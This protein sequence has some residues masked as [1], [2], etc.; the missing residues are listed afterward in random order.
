LFPENFIV[1]NPQFSTITYRNNS[2][3]S[4]YHSMQAQVTLRPTNGFS[5][6]GTY[7]WAKNLGIPVGTGAFTDPS[8][9]S[10]DYTYTAS[11]RAH[12]FRSNGTLELPFGPNKL[13]LGNSSGWLARVVERWQASVILNLNSG[14]R[15]DI[16]ATQGAG[17]AVTQT[18]LYGNAVPDVVGPFNPD[19]R[20]RWN[21]NNNATGTAHGGTYFN[22]PSPL[23]RVTDPQCAIT[24][25]TDRMGFN[26][27]ANGSCTLDALADAQTGQIILQNPRPGTRGNLGQNTIELPGSWSFD[28]NVSKTFRVGESK[29]LQL[30]IDA[31]N[32]LNHPVPND[33]DLGLNSTGA[34]LF[35]D[36]DEKGNQVRQFQGQVRFN[37]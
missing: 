23:V 15:Q 33:P 25:Y 14:G 4:N 5:Y 8:D 13:V 24:N 26:M 12:D 10:A 36:I 3:S 2:D 6:Q 34:T 17:F 9:R 16:A 32:V 1:V 11:H 19:P 21:G 29:S 20:V 35:G 30:R 27:F 7:T 37:F 22:N 18:G 28:A 31:I